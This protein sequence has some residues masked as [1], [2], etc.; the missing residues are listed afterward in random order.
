MRLV[1]MKGPLSYDSSVV[2]GVIQQPRQHF[3]PAHLQPQ[4][5]FLLPL[6]FLRCSVRLLR[7][8]G[9]A[10]C[11]W[12]LPALKSMAWTAYAHPAECGSPQ[13]GCHAPSSLHTAGNDNAGTFLRLSN[14]SW[15][16]EES[17]LV[18]CSRHLPNLNQLLG[19]HHLYAVWVACCS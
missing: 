2:N 17:G 12:L 18:S 16:L 19:F 1:N 14:L 13:P 10:T 5:W 15:W 3:S 7:L 11:G 8:S 4:V 9:W 6:S